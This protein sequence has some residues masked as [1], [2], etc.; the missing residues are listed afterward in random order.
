MQEKFIVTIKAVVD[1]EL[2]EQD[3]TQELMDKLENLS[4]EGFE[5]VKVLDWE[6]KDIT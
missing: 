3:E 5:D 4:I 1:T 6:I 2:K